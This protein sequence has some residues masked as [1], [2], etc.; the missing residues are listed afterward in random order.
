MGT[1]TGERRERAADGLISFVP[2]L[3]V[4]LATEPGN[5]H[6][7]VAGSMLS[8]DISGFTALSERLAAKGKAGA[9]EI[10]ELINVCFDA[11]IGEA[12]AQNGEILKFGGDAILVMFR[13]DDHE[14]R[15]VTAAL[16]MQRTLH[17]LPGAKRASLTMTVGAH[18]GVF[19]AFLVGSGYRELIV[20]G[21][22]ATHVI[23]LEG[24][25]EKGETLVS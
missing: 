9:E 19:D 14:R 21:A 25:A 8:A 20:T 6:V 10:T 11:L 15:C 7:A 4:E 24:A 23:A 18:T 1:S 5:R 12:Y 22:E 2:R 17:S 16:A 3:A 13:G